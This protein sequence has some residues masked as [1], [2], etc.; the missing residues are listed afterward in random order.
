MGS[1]FEA[2]DTLQI[3]SEQGFPKELDY[4][5]HLRSP[6][7]ASDFTNKTFKFHGKSNIRLFHIPPVRVFLVHNIDDHWLYWGL[8][9]IT[10]LTLDYVNHTTSGEYKIV[11]IYT[12][13]QMQQAEFILHDDQAS[14]YIDNLNNT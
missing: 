8:I 14:R 1:Y 7:T 5:T 10:Q 13:E 11:R 12:P 6:L 3:T 4:Q 2:N 9:H